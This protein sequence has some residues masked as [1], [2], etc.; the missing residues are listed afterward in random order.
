MK[1]ATLQRVYWG[2]IGVCWVILR[3]HWG[4]IRVIWGTP[5]QDDAPHQTQPATTEAHVYHAS[6]AYPKRSILMQVTKK[7]GLGLK[8]FEV[9]RDFHPAVRF[10]VSAAQHH[11]PKEVFHLKHAATGLD[12]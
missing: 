12:V 11:G 6:L 4:F 7:L 5:Q 2:Y 9:M 10:S 1:E 3:L 8:A